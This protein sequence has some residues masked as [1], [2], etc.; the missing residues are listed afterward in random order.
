M[1]KCCICFATSAA[2]SLLIFVQMQSAERATQ[3]NSQ[4]DEIARNTLAWCADWRS[5][6]RSWKFGAT[7]APNPNPG[8]MEEPALPTLDATPGDDGPSVLPKSDELPARPRT[9]Q[10]AKASSERVST[11]PSSGE[12]TLDAHKQARAHE[13]ARSTDPRK[14]YRRQSSSHRVATR[15]THHMSRRVSGRHH[16]EKAIIMY[17]PCGPKLTDVR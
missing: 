7:A 2:G 14:G 6:G 4:T 12:Q 1:S 16:Y 15:E 3:K 9:D 10:R 13:A 17:N 8:E 5:H 11:R